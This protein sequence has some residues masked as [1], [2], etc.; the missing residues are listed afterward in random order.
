MRS[1]GLLKQNET[2][3]PPYKKPQKHHPAYQDPC[4]PLLSRLFHGVAWHCL[5][6]TAVFK[7]VDEHALS[8]LIYL[9]DLAWTCY[10]DSSINEKNSSNQQQP[11]MDLNL[12][13]STASSLPTSSKEYSYVS[14]KTDTIEKLCPT[15][16][17]KIKEADVNH[18]CCENDKTKNLSKKQD[19]KSHL[20]DRWF[21]SDD[22][23]ENLCMTITDFELPSSYF[24]YFFGSDS[25]NTIPPTNNTSTAS[26]LVTNVFDILTPNSSFHN[27]G[28]C[29]YAKPQWSDRG[30]P[31]ASPHSK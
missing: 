22:L 30:N 28:N 2:L 11:P 20:L 18:A 16:R 26:T 1:V 7:D 9:L 13:L 8:L 31:T 25:E 23:A 24:H 17:I 4:R 21:N 12:D 19:T 10:I 6:R 15:K 14:S 3:W 5:Y 29:M 27:L